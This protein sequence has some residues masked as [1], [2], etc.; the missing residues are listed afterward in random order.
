MNSERLI[1]TSK[2]SWLEYLG[3]C[4]TALLFYIL[5][6]SASAAANDQAFESP[7]PVLISTANSTRALAIKA[8]NWRGALPERNSEVFQPGSRVVIFVTNVKL[9]PE[10]KASAFRVYAEDASGKQYSLT[11]ENIQQLRK[12]DWIYG[13]TVHIHDRSVYNGQPKPD[14]DVLIRVSWRGNTSNRVRLGLGG[15][16]GKIKDDAGAVPTP[17][18]QTRR[19]VKSTRSSQTPAADRKRFMEQAAFGPTQ[20]LDLRLRQIGLRRWIEE[21]FETPYPTIAYP[22]FPLKPFDGPES[23]GIYGAS[24]ETDL[25]HRNHYWNYNNQKWMVQEALYGEDQLRRRVSWALHQIWVVSHERINQ[26]R[27]MQEYIEIL[28]RNAFGNYRDLMKEMTLN[29]AM[30]EYLDMI[31][32]TRHNPN[33]NYPRE[34]LQ[35]FTVGLYMLNQ[36]GTPVLDEQGNPIP[37]FDQDKIEQFTKIFTGWTHCNNGENPACPNAVSGMWNL[38]D[39]MYLVFPNNHDQTEKV[40]FDYPDAPNS[41]IEACSDCEAEEA[42]RAYANDSLEKTLDNIFYHPNVG[43][44][45]GKLLIQH[46]VTSNPSPAYV[47]RVAAAFNDNAAGVRGDMKAVIKAVLLDPEARGSQKTDPAYGKLREP[48][49]LITN[50]LRTFNVRAGAF[51]YGNPATPPESCQNRSDGVLDSVM[52]GMEQDIWNPPSVFN[53]FP[54]TFAVPG[55]DSPGPEFALAN[56]GLSFERNNNIFLFTMDG[57][58][59]FNPPS[60]DDPYPY[61]PCGTSIDLSEATTWATADPGGNRLVEEL[62]TKMMHGTMSEA[63]KIKIRTAINANVPIKLKAKQAIFLVASSSQYQIQR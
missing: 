19:L 20:A 16:G 52:R 25:C 18:P 5:T 60:P 30:G 39:S 22:N 37:T 21:Q 57:G 14:G 41:I 8:D 26:Q 43:P 55:T 42:S 3:A 49:Q 33:E 2:H 17:A 44:F 59:S 7:K 54:P 15:T 63:M 45:I 32:S 35:L 27:G 53:Y 1:L 56:T 10:E 38:I 36:D 31:R 61:V 12:Q 62:N 48:L 9:L 6:V 4:L 46:L 24:L 34:L 28:D 51:S 58:Q 23:C 13:L 40:L 50:L 47:A 11:V 29:P